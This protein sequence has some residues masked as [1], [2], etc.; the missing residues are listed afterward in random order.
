MGRHKKVFD[1]KE[2]A[3]TIIKTSRWLMDSI[4]GITVIAK[5]TKS[6][7]KEVI[8]LLPFQSGKEVSKWE[9]IKKFSIK[10]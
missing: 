4:V 7:L 10:M 6:P 1:Q 5:V 9:G 3:K 8:K 2:I